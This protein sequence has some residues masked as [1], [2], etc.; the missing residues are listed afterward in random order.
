MARNILTLCGLKKTVHQRLRDQFLQKWHDDIFNS[1]K[2][3][4]YRIFKT[5]FECEEYFSLLP[6]KLQKIFVKFR[7]TNHHLPVGQV[8]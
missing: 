2:G 5:N 3:I 4:I 8:V 1:S 6:R 7:T